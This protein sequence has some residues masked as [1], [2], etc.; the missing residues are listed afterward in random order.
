[1]PIA[2]KPKLTI[3]ERFQRMMA[4]R[5]EIYQQFVRW[6]L[7]LRQRGFRRY[8]A[9]AIMHVIRFHTHLSQKPGEDFKISNDL[10]SR[11]ARQ[12]VMEYPEQLTGFFQLRELKTP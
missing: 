1:M 2:S 10:V 12:A 9:D 6:A 3:D 5:P 4:K 7:Q 8:S 11:Y